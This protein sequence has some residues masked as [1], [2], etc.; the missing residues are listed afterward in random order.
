[1]PMR[2]TEELVNLIA[3]HRQPGRREVAV[4]THVQHPYEITPEMVEAVNRLRLRGIPVYNQLVYTF[5][6]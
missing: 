4:M 6:M 2:Y 5:Y 1:M 3:R